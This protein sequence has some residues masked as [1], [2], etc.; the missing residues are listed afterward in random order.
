MEGGREG[1][2]EGERSNVSNS[3]FFLCRQV[4]CNALRVWGIELIPF[5]SP[6]AKQARENPQ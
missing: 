1:G 5:L 6:E 2:R 4:I 3:Q